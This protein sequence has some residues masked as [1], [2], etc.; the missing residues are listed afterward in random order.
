MRSLSK[1]LLV[2]LLIVT[3]GCKEEKYPYVGYFVANEGTLELNASGGSASITA[4][5]DLSDPIT[6]EK[7]SAEWV[8]A[9]VEG[10]AITVTAVEP[11]PGDVVRKTTVSVRCGTRVADIPVQQK[12]TPFTVE[13]PK[14]E[15]GQGSSIQVTAQTELADGIEIVSVNSEWFTATASG[16][17]ITITAK[18]T[19]WDENSRTGTMRVKCGYRITDI[20][21]EQNPVKF[22]VGYGIIPASG[23]TVTLTVDTNLEEAIVI[24]KVSESWCE[25]NS[26]GDKQIRVNV[27]NAN[28]DIEKDR[29]ASV[30]VKCGQRSAKFTVIQIFNGQE[31][32]AHDWAKWTATGSDVQ[33]DDGGGYPSLF[34][35]EQTNF[36][37]SQWSPAT[38]NPHW[39]L[40][41]MKEE[42][43]VGMVRIARRYYAGNGNYFPS[44]KTLEVYTS[45][46]GVTFGEKVGGFTF[47][48]PWIAPDGTI[49]SGNSS[50]VPPY[51]DVIFTTPVMARYMKLVIAETNNTTGVCQVAY[52][53]AFEKI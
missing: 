3:Y 52:F 27:R 43:S 35:D 29:R 24:E 16:K 28:P 53:K 13:S 25:V 22:V 46:D 17:T 33:A 30:S 21:V 31:Y 44:V 20:T 11:N 9:S 18:D 12:F 38:P 7:I 40:I 5:T 37:H 39:L 8:S 32:F 51:E 34:K 36:W 23:G 45:T 15:A 4:T 10:R 42:L 1:I 50:K 6:I 48:L 41:D 19:N 2:F 14:V 49:V 26:I 47:V